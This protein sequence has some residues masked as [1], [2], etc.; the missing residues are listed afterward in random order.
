MVRQFY[1]ITYTAS[2][3]RGR[4]DFVRDIPAESAMQAIQQMMWAL[5]QQH[6]HDH[7]AYEFERMERRREPMPKADDLEGV[8][9]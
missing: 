8:P 4:A 6:P 1:R 2:D 3:Q 7:A 9:A 5:E